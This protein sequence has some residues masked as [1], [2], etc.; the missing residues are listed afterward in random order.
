MPDGPVGDPG[1]RRDA[2]DPVDPVVR[3]GP[4]V[5]ESLAVAL[6]RLRAER[7]ARVVV[8]DLGEAEGTWDDV[9]HRALLAR[10]VRAVLATDLP[11]VAVLGDRVTTATCAVA[12]ACD[13]VVADRSTSV[14][15]APPA[16]GGLSLTLPAAVGRLRAR[17]MLLLGEAVTA[18][19]AADWGVVTHLAPSG[20]T[21]RAR[22]DAVVRALLEADAL[23]LAGTRRV[24]DADLAA[25]LEEALAHEDRTASLLARHAAR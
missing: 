10:C 22:A 13:A 16:V 9:A 12:L 15:I 14:Q 3:L 8:L 23:T 21:A 18:V 2:A 11:V 20:S 7:G 25:R 1:T 24:L 5:D 19:S 4:R 17:R 6:E